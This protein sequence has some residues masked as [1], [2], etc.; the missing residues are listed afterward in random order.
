MAS[1]K[2]KKKKKSRP[3]SETHTPPLKT[4]E[5]TT[6]QEHG[7]KVYKKK[8]VL[9]IAAGLVI[10][11][12]L[13]FIVRTVFPGGGKMDFR[14]LNVILVTI[15]TLRADHVGIYEEGNADTPHL[16]ALAREGVLFERCIAQT[17]LTLPSHTS[18]LSGTYPLYHRVRDNGGFRVPGQLEFVS[19]VLKEK[20]FSTSA[21]I[22]AFVLHSRWGINQGFDTYSDEFEISKYKA[23]LLEND[24][25]A[26]SVLAD[27]S[28]WIKKNKDKQFFTWIHLY[29]PHTP[30]NPPSPYDEKNPG[31]PYRGEVEYTD[32]QLGAFFSFLKENNLY[33][34]CLIIAAADHG[35][36]LGEH[37]EE[38]HGLFIYE[39]AVW[40]PLIIKAPVEFPV[41]RIKHVVEL[42]DLAPTILHMLDIQVPRSYQGESVLNLMLGKERKKE[43]IAYTETFYPRLHFGWSALKA[44][45]RGEW[46]Y[47]SAPGEEL[48]KVD[49]DRGEKEN[50]ALREPSEAK[51]IK[52]RI[53]HFQK[54]KSKN[55]LSPGAIKNMAKKDLERLRSLGY[56][57][58]TAAVE[59]SLEK[60]LPDAKDKI[61]VYQDFKE[62]EKRMNEG[63]Y[64]EAI[65]RITSVI[66]SDP[67]IIDAH[68]LLG[69]CYRNKGMHREAI[70]SFYHVLEMK[71]DYNFTM[72]DLVTSL[73]ALNQYEKAK[74]EIRKFLKRF[75]QDYILYEMLGNVYF[76]QQ[77]Y[78]NALKP[79]EKSIEIEKNNATALR[80][81]GHIYLIKKEYNKARSFLGQALKIN[82]Q[83][84]EIYYLL[85]L[86]EEENGALANAVDYYKK[87]LENNP[88][89]YKAS[90]NLAEDL[91]KMGS[92][93]QAIGYYRKTIQNQPLFK[94]PY[95]MIANYYLGKKENLTEAIELCKKGIAIKPEDRYTLFGYFVLT[96]IYNL[97][98][99]TENLRF[100]SEKGERLHQA[101]R[102]AGQK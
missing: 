58:G 35:E 20:G 21:F 13:Y 57:T 75:P 53:W 70:E 27:A 34:K 76:Y 19:E 56:V 90:Y 54:Q 96:N 40:V 87:E 68:V 63:K 29:D 78:E 81:V 42:V 10:L 14:G 83:L 28:A 50:L 33:D 1:K 79:Y 30:Y 4:E 47:I 37:G 25:N 64:D 7:R 38:E 18:I 62:A 23:I 45:Y 92:P 11:I 73:N 12:G 91:R 51:R 3:L 6:S 16:D 61:H 94:M 5:A 97:L 85:A 67:A 8:T 9:S 36:C 15:D 24:R 72:I 84:K 93:D 49:I 17:P 32:H 65:Q 43:N 52:K 66:R 69:Q 98:N 95:F 46:K 71:P 77:D 39:S 44:F 48:Y 80:Q 31:N 26:E 55:A 100:Y 2:R 88:R 74:E 101:L 59:T 89:D 60:N 102:D 41:K 86:I 82:P 99:D 22:G